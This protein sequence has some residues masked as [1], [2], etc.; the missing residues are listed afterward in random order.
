MLACSLA[1]DWP[2]GETV[3]AAHADEE[4][5]Y[6]LVQHTLAKIVLHGNEAFTDDELKSALQIR[7]Q[8][9]LH[10]FTTARYRPDLIGGQLR[11]LERYYQKRGFHQVIV[12]HDSTVQDTRLHGDVLYISLQEGPRTILDEVLFVGAEPLR[13]NQLRSHLELL[14]GVPAP[15]D[16]NDFGHD[17][18]ALRD[19]YWDHAFLQVAIEP[20]LTREPTIDPQRFSAMI[21]YRITPGQQFSIRNIHITG[22]ELTRTDLI[23]REL[24]VEEGGLFKWGDIDRSRRELLDTALLRDVSF[25]PADVDSAAGLADLLVQVVERRPAYYELGAG[26]GSRERYRLLGAWGHNNMWGS[27]RRLFLRGKVYWNVEEIAGGLRKDARPE[28]NYRADVLYINPHL[29]GSRFRLD[30]NLYLEK[31]TRGE[32][33]LNLHTLGFALGT[34]FRGSERVLN[35]VAL[36]LE[37]SDPRLHPG[38]PD[39]LRIWFNASQVRKSQTRSLVYTFIEEA[40]NDVFNPTGGFLITAQVEIAGGLLAGDNSFVRGLASWHG[41]TELPLGGVLAFRTSMGVVEPYGGSRERGADGVPYADRFFAGG[42]SSV[43][44][45]LESSL[46][47]QITDPARLDALQFASDVPLPDNPARGGNYMLLTNV[48]WR[49]PLPILS[50]LRLGGVLFMDGGNVWTQARDIRLEGFRL[51]SYPRE[52]DEHLAT[53]LWDYRYSI[54]TGVRLDTPFGPFRVDVGFPLKRA[55]EDDRV[56]YHF[57]LGYPF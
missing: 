50:R 25:L 46:G 41:Y 7:E 6:G 36:Q 4:L 22:N 42:V 12:R 2:A 28:I 24:R 38:A 57:S 55:P 30:I 49:F 1:S 21:E 37:E 26:F 31:E 51:R 33:G 52:P 32:S 13:E 16:L 27:G 3:P 45:Y 35:T 54:G 5:D 11:Q 8:N 9:W 18:Y 34:Q 48:E 17:L 39:S 47:P 43:R 40:R 53:K 19:L 15:S 14:E 44:G 29:R 56:M 20:V 23:A 10:L